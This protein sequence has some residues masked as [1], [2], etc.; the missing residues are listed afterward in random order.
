MERLPDGA[1]DS[2]F[3]L[4]LPNKRFMEM[5]SPNLFLGPSRA[6]PRTVPSS[7]AELAA[8]PNK[9]CNITGE[10][11]ESSCQMNY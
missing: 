10:D 6:E 9:V 3:L 2:Y 8:S 5:N 7:E 4:P 1:P 11:R